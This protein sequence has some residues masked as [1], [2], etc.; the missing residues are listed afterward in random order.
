MFDALVS[1]FMG[2][3][4]GLGEL[5]SLGFSEALYGALTALASGPFLAG[6]GTLMAVL[7]PFILVAAVLVYVLRNRTPSLI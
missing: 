3:Y 5:S 4:F 6:V 2:L 1:T 7:L